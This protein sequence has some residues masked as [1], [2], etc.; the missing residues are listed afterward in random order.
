MSPHAISPSMPK[1]FLRPCLLLL[2]RERPSH[3]YELIERLTMLGF[4]ESDPGGLYRG[5]RRLEA[6]GLVRS[7]WER[8][9]GAPQRR[10]YS[11]T[12]AGRAELERR[13]RELAE[14]EKRIDTFLRRFLEASRTRPAAVPRHAMAADAVSAYP[15]VARE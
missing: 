14:A 11:L 1:D 5:L 4:D 8:S 9:H 13:A 6:D 3:G 7:S 2:L 10:T 15:S 12:D